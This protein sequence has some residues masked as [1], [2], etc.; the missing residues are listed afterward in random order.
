MRNS[1]DR[2]FTR[3]T[4]VSVEILRSLLTYDA[5]TGELTWL[6]RPERAWNTRYAGKRALNTQGDY[7]YCYGS[8]F[9]VKYRAHRVIWAIYYGEWPEGEIDHINRDRLDNRISNLRCVTT[10][11]NA[12]NKKM[13]AANK[14]GVT[15]VSWCTK[16]KRWRAQIQVKRKNHCLGAF[17]EKADAIKVRQEAELEYGF[18]P[19]HGKAA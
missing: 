9:N 13:L 17:I 3:Q 16:Q 11:V 14:S 18:H 2:R 6:P 12:Q 7:G 10:L 1:L 8:I 4:T 15:G 5:E 19:N